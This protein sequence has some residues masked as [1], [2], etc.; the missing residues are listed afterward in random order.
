M[1]IKLSQ[2]LLSDLL[3]SDHFRSPLVLGAKE[4]DKV[5]KKSLYYRDLR[6]KRP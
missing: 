5:D 3:F 2:N 6:Q 4:I 1:T